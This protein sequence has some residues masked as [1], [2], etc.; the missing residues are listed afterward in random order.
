C[1]ARRKGPDCTI[2]FTGTHTM[3]AKLR[4]PALGSSKTEGRTKT[5]RVGQLRPCG[6][7]FGPHVRKFKHPRNEAEFF[8]RIRKLPVLAQHFKKVRVGVPKPVLHILF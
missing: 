6:F 2:P 1:L 4:M 5:P 3:R 7:V 8:A